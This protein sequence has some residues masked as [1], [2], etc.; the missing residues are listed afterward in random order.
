MPEYFFICNEFFEIMVLSDSH[1][2]AF[3]VMSSETEIT[4]SDF[5]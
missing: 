1:D 3:D 2:S 4:V 5:L